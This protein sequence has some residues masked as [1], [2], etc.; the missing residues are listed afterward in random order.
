MIMLQAWKPQ[1]SSME[2][3][4]LGVEFRGAV[5]SI[6]AAVDTPPDELEDL[7]TALFLSR[8]D[9]VAGLRPCGFLLPASCFVSL[10]GACKDLALLTGLGKPV[11]L[12]V[13]F[14]D[15]EADEA[16]GACAACVVVGTRTAQSKYF[17]VDVV[18]FAQPFNVP[19]FKCVPSSH[20]PDPA[21]GYLVLY[22]QKRTWQRR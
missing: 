12:L 20:C 3:L 22:S 11:Q 14:V 21:F 5:R 17:A 6:A 1:T 13:S 15:D 19:S 10:A 7:L 2:P 8:D 9:C 18:C 4:V 16:I